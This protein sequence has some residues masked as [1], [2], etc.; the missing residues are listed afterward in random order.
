MFWL[1]CFTV[2]LLPPSKFELLEIKP[3]K[4]NHEKKNSK[5]SSYP[6]DFFSYKYYIWANK[7]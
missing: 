6:Y 5:C 4:V 2:K 1:N 7:T 3:Y